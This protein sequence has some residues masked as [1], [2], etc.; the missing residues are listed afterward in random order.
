M[1]FPLLELVEA[2]DSGYSNSTASRQSQS[3]SGQKAQV[4][5]SCQEATSVQS[6]HSTTATDFCDFQRCLKLN[7]EVLGLTPSEGRVAE[8]ITKPGYLR[9]EAVRKALRQARLK[10]EL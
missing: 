10:I 6:G 4:K 1:S 3:Q 7:R 5:V 9:Y 2:C 8:L